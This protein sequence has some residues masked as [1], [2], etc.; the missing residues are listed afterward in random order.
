MQE[1][2]LQ[3]HSLAFVDEG[4]GDAVL[5]LHSLAGSLH[6]WDMLSASLVSTHRVLRFDARGHGA[7]RGDVP[8]T[9]KDYAGDALALL[10]ARGIQRC[11]VV[12]I[13]MGGQA[14]M[15]MA[16]AAPSSVRGLVLANTSAG[17]S[18]VAANR[19]EQACRRIDEIGYPA[20]AAEYVASRLAHGQNAPGY[21]AY[22]RDT[23]AL[24][25]TRYLDTFEDILSQDLAVHL[26]TLAMPALLIA[27]DL[28]ISTTPE[29]MR[30][31]RGLIP[32]SRLTELSEAGHFSCLD[33][34]G[35]FLDAVQP[36]LATLPD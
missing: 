4:E 29:R 34:P 1:L 2:D 12:G 14:A 35:A 31:L 32:E 17:A 3:T 22:L 8:F 20:F 36:F 25:A 6:M 5:L 15:W 27:G 7:T 26:P 21:A 33:Q 10:E 18:A 19:F 28:D 30:A 16:L 11:A 13:S 24:G 9:V 23:L